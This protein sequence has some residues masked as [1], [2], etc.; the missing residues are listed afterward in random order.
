MTFVSLEF[1][2]LLI[3]T[4]VLYYILPQRGRMLLMLT[5]SYVFYCFWN[6]VY[7]LLIAA[8][9]VIDYAMAIF[10]E[11]SLNLKK[12]R[13]GL[14][15]SISGNMG[16]LCYFKY[17]DF[18]LD[19]LKALL[20]PLGQNLPGPLELI[21]PVGISF[22]TFQTLS[23]T[24]DVYRGQKSAERDFILVA[25]F[26]SFFPQLVAGPIER[27]KALMPQLKTRQ[28]FDF[29]NIEAGIGL[30]LWGLIKKIVISD[31][32]AHVAYKA[33]LNPSFFDS[34]TLIFSA[35]A[36]FVVVY[37]DFSAYSEI[38]RGVARLFGIRLSINFRYP[39]IAGNISQYWSRWHITLSHWIRDYL[40]APLGGL[41]I[42]DTM[43]QAR[44]TL[45]AMSLVGLWH[46]AQWTFVLWGFCHGVSLV[47]YRFIHLNF[48]R[49]YRGS[50]ITGSY[51][52]RFCSWGFSTV[53][54]IALTVLFFSPSIASA[55]KFY[56]KVFINP[57]FRAHIPSGIL[58]GFA[59][60]ALFQVF[61]YYQYRYSPGASFQ[62]LYPAFKGALYA[63]AVFLVLFGSVETPEPFIYF[64]F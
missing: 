57:V 16:M 61:H 55:S 53:I 33:F 58:Y 18:A 7:G 42:R 54:R 25:L 56:D 9:T 37:L 50:A 49:R 41:R 19:S 38:A 10:I 3:V 1:A 23:Y 43:H 5:A 52:W 44:V 32:L 22:Y 11:N 26:V 24:I 29:T 6:P 12:R 31:R 39:Q 51:P 47:V 20:G 34:L 64:Q 13:I 17:T 45:L 60:L 4:L 59:F 36:M 63:A 48:L 21:L 35:T 28:P 27:A 14:L 40:V 30:I 62:R 2:F 46:G 8:S 15:V